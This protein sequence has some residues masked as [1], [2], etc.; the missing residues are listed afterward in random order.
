MSINF[1]SSNKIVVFFRCWGQFWKTK[2]M[3]KDNSLCTS[4]MGSQ[5]KYN[6][7]LGKYVSTTCTGQVINFALHRDAC[8]LA[9]FARSNKNKDMNIKFKVI[10]H[11][12]SF[13]AANIAEII[14]ARDNET[15]SGNTLR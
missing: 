10:L 12:M 7:S 3:H 15:C 11:L 14:Y 4:R 6:D 5:G 1:K 9:W 2:H 13:N 8:R